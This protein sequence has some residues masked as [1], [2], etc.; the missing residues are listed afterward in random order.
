MKIQ[1]LAM[2]TLFALIFAILWIYRISKGER[3]SKLFTGMTVIGFVLYGAAL[4]ALI[5]N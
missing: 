5:W 4:L 2:P 1:Y 3:M